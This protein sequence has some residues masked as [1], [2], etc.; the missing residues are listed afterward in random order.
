MKEDRTELND[1]SADRPDVLTRMIQMYEDCAE[2]VGAL[3]WPLE[4]GTTAA[5][6]VVTKHIH[7]VG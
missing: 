5:P 2:R 6:R 3:P 4:H 1:L 7:D